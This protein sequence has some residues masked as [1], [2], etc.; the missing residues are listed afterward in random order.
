MPIKP[1]SRAKFID[2]KGPWNIIIFD[3]FNKLLIR[4]EIRGDNFNHQ[5][6]PNTIKCFA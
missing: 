3:H 5:N 1:I 2:R 4:N 6:I